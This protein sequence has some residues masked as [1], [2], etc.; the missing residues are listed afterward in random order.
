[1]VETDCLIL[2]NSLAGR[3][4]YT[5]LRREAG[6]RIL[7]V[8]PDPQPGASIALVRSGE[9]AYPRIPVLVTRREAEELLGTLPRGCAEE[10]VLKPTVLKEGD[11]R[12][13]VLGYERGEY[14]EPWPLRWRGELVFMTR[15]IE[16]L[17]RSGVLEPLGNFVRSGVRVVDLD[18]RVA[19]LSIGTVVRFRCLVSTFPID[20]L[21]GKV[22]S[23]ANLFTPDPQGR[24]VGFYIAS[25]L[26]ASPSPIAGVLYHATRASRAHTFLALPLNGMQLLYIIAS[27]SRS[28]PPMPGFTEKLFSEARRFGLLKGE[29][30]MEYSYAT[31]YGALSVSP[32]LRMS[33]DVPFLALYGRTALWKEMSVV[34]VVRGAEGA[35]ERV[36]ATL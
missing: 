1:M 15:P 10:V 27:Y 18:R 12:A 32:P 3:A 19:Q 20:V 7:V 5:V 4:V 9:Y 22:R 36:L 30:V 34:E 35:A 6:L 11:L 29:I 26:I 28:Y 14:Q 33:H 25:L 24:S 2:G 17:E 21:H 13:K 8:D 16:C 31:M 23:S